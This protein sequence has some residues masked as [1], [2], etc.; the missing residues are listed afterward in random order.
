MG[1]AVEVSEPTGSEA[2][3]LDEHH[4]HAP[5]RQLQPHDPGEDS[6]RRLGGPVGSERGYRHLTCTAQCW[7]VLATYC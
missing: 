7:T 1:N 4:L 2:G 3:W 5:L 6:Q